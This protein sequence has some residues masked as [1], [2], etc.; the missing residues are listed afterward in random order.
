[1]SSI[2]PTSRVRLTTLIACPRIVVND[3]KGTENREWKGLTGAPSVP[4]RRLEVFLHFADE[5]TQRNA[6]RLRDLGHVHQSDV[7]RASLDVPDVG[8]VDV[9]K[10]RKRFLR[11]ALALSQPTNSEPERRFRVG[12]F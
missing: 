11:Q 5:A 9:R 3:K 10:F 8:A 2:P 6:E 4:D 7:A 1:M 12:M